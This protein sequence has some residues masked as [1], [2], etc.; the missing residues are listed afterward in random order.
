MVVVGLGVVVVIGISFVVVDVDFVEV[1]DW[2]VVVE[3]V[4]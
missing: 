3:L 4:G 1:V 2:E